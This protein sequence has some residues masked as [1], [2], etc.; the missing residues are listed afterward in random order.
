MDWNG[1]GEAGV[2]G[3]FHGYGMISIRDVGY[4]LQVCSAQRLR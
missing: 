1:G 2:G 4:S 3:L